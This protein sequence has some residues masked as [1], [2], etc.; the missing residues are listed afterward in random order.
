VTGGIPNGIPILRERSEV[1]KLRYAMLTLTR[2]LSAER[3]HPLGIGSPPDVDYLRHQ[4]EMAQRHPGA[5]PW[6]S[7]LIIWVQ[8]N[9]HHLLALIDAYE[10]RTPSGDGGTQ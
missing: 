8:Q 5:E 7:N 6:R 4:I 3:R 1:E 2:I 9:P 10:R